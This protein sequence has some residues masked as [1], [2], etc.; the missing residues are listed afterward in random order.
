MAALSLALMVD[1]SEVD[2]FC[3]F[4]SASLEIFAFH[5]LGGT[6]CFLVHSLAVLVNAARSL[7]YCVPISASSGFSGAPGFSTVKSLTKNKE[8]NSGPNATTPDAPGFG[9]AIRFLSVVN[10]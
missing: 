10:T 3:G 9:V 7:T 4:S 8:T 1:T 5:L 6:A 2:M